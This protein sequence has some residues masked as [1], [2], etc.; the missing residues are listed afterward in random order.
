MLLIYAVEC[1]LKEMLLGRRGLHS[2][3]KLAE[4]DLTHD[5]DFLLKILGARERFGF[6]R[7]TS[8]PTALV[9][10]GNVHQALRYGARMEVNCRRD[11]EKHA[12]AVIAWIE[13]NAT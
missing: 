3:E 10:S 12:K 8:P 9:S 6:S 1:G 13:E 2:T 5:L 4:D 7:L 11:L